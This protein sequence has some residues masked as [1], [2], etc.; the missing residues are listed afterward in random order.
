MQNFVTSEGSHIV[1]FKSQDVNRFSLCRHKFHFEGLL[2]GI[3]AND[4]PNV[5]TSEFY[6]R[7][8]ALEYNEI[9]LFNMTIYVS[10]AG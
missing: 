3:N 10:H 5:S 8:V 6:F 7:H 2:I 9:M 4:S 1:A